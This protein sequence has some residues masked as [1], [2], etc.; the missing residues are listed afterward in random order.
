M[1]FALRRRLHF[2]RAGKHNTDRV[3][4]ENSDASNTR[5]LLGGVVGY[6]S[7]RVPTIGRARRSGQA[8]KPQLPR[9]RSNLL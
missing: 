7:V 5:S 2:G 4:E 8:L 9:Q 3:D 1:M 6:T